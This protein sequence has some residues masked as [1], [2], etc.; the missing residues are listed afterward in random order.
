MNNTSGTCTWTCA[1]SKKSLSGQ[2][3]K[4]ILRAT[5]YAVRILSFITSPR[6]PVA[7]RVPSIFPF[8]LSNPLLNR[9]LNDA[10]IYNAEP[11]K[12]IFMN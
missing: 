10:S 12:I 8:S 2:R 3:C 7:S 6:C 9:L 5:V 11:P 4:R 1:F